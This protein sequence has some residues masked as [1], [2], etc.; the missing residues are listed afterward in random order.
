MEKWAR[1]KENALVSEHG[2]Q[3]TYK[4]CCCWIGSSSARYRPTAVPTKV[5]KTLVLQTIE[6]VISMRLD[7]S[8]AQKRAIAEINLIALIIYLS[9]WSGDRCSKVSKADGSQAPK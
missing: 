2:S 6:R 4:Y 9:T 1:T 5:M 8:L 7:D 3:V